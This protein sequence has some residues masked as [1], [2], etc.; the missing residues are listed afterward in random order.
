MTIPWYVIGFFITCALFSMNIIPQEVSVLC[1]EIS[2]KLEIIALAA[3]GLKVNVKD[4]VK[5]GKEVS[6]YGLFVGTVQVVSAVV[7]IKIFI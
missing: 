5:Q 7:L 4:L 2:N 3:I 1:K 6:L